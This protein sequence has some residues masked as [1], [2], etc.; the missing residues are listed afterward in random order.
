MCPSRELYVWYSVT[1]EPCETLLHSLL[2]RHCLYWIY[3]RELQAISCWRLSFT[4]LSAENFGRN[5]SHEISITGVFHIIIATLTFSHDS[6]TV[7]IWLV[8]VLRLVSHSNAFYPLL[9]DTL[10]RSPL[11]FTVFLIHAICFRR[12]HL[13]SISYLVFTAL[14][15]LLQLGEHFY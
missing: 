5:L 15:W 2:C 14:Q 4:K 7:A 12:L 6:V 3:F 9:L 1:Y 11:C 13:N 10:L 8:V